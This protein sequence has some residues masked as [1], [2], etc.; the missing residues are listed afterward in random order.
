MQQGCLI[1][2]TR[3]IVR[4]SYMHMKNMKQFQFGALYYVRAF[5]FEHDSIIKH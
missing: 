2:F 4:T 5:E 3:F 1:H